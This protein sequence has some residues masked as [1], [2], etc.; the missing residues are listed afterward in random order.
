MTLEWMGSRFLHF[1]ETIWPYPVWQHPWL[2]SLARSSVENVKAQALSSGQGTR[3]TIISARPSGFRSICLR[4]WKG[5]GSC[6]QFPFGCLR[7]GTSQGHNPSFSFRLFH[8]VI[9]FL[10]GIPAM[11]DAHLLHRV[12]G[13]LL[14]MET[15]DDASGFPESAAYNLRIEP[16]R[17]KVIQIDSLR[18]VNAFEDFR[19][20]FGLVPSTMAIRQPSRW[21]SRLVR[22][23]VQL[24]VER[25]IRSMATGPMFSGN[26][27][28]LSAWPRSAIRG[29]RWVFLVLLLECTS[30]YVIEIIKRTAGHQGCL[31]T[32]LLKDANSFPVA[33]SLVVT[34]KSIGIEKLLRY[35]HP[36]RGRLR[37][38]PEWLFVVTDEVRHTGLA[39]NLWIHSGYLAEF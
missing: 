12:A 18:L 26:T 5:S 28:H 35:A 6:Q 1:V 33:D 31:I 10:D 8:F 14:D 38:L 27:S 11:P 3:R 39:W 36:S 19:H 9:A 15:V 24:A 4:L 17:P 20:V 25:T 22:E 30:V 13:K 21:R 23:G 16:D 37:R 29:T 2:C 32:S 34:S 7:S